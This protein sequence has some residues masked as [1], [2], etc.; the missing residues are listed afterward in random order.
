[1]CQDH[2][3]MTLKTFAAYTSVASNLSTVMVTVDE[4]YKVISGGGQLI[5]GDILMVESYP[6]DEMTWVAKFKNHGTDLS[7][8]GNIA[9]FAIGLYD[10]DNLWD[11]MVTSMESSSSDGPSET[12]GL[13]DGYQITGGGA[14]VS[15]PDSGYGLVLFESYPSSDSGWTATANQHWY[16]GTGRV[17]AYAI[18]IKHTLECLVP[19]CSISSST[20]SAASH[21]ATTVT[22]ADDMIVGGGAAASL[23]TDGSN[24]AGNILVITAPYLETAAGQGTPMGGKQWT[25]GAKD[26][27]VGQ[28]GTVTAYTIQCAASEINY[29]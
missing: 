4:G 10:P 22:L 2:M 21:P 3:Q 19:T 11:V 18:G 12:A 7:K 6:L 25:V 8:V 29:L 24:L 13:P 16:A 15:T 17:T 14:R 28:T 5:D 9:A 20:S 27:K 23:P 26:H 1:M